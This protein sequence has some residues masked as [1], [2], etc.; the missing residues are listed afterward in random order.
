MSFFPA[1][2]IGGLHEV[3]ASLKA[4]A[5]IGVMWLLT[6]GMV[7]LNGPDVLFGEAR[8]IQDTSLIHLPVSKVSHIRVCDEQLDGRNDW[9]QSRPVEVV[10]TVGAGDSFT[11]L[12]L[13]FLHN[14]ELDEVNFIA[15]EVSRYVC[16][17]AGATPRMAAEFADRFRALPSW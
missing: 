3:K 8:T 5:R 1:I 4:H 7:L 10:D 15:N 14:L 6:S 2:N 13:G 17:Q 9:E 16:S 12:V 11:P